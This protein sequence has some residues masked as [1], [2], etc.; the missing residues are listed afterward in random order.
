MQNWLRGAAYAVA[1]LV[2]GVGAGSAFAAEIVQ[3]EVGSTP[4][5]NACVEVFNSATANNTPVLASNCGDGFPSYWHWAPNVIEG[6]GSANGVTTCL[7][8]K[9]NGSVVLRVCDPLSPAPGEAWYFVYG[10]VRVLT[11]P[12]AGRCLDSRGF[13]GTTTT[14]QL[15]VDSCT[16]GATQ[17]WD[18]R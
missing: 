6:I 14:A 13:Y 9:L 16:G 4:V 7:R 17:Q 2:M 5:V 3:P 1:C 11:G 10:E 8:A 15:V 12:L 18:I